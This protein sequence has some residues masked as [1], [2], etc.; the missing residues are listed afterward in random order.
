M[1]FTRFHFVE[2]RRI[3]FIFK[4]ILINFL[5]IYDTFYVGKYLCNFNTVAHPL[6]LPVSIVPQFMRECV[7]LIFHFL[8][9][10]PCSTRVTLKYCPSCFNSC[11]VFKFLTLLKWI[12][13][14]S[15][16]R[17]HQL[18]TNHCADSILAHSSVYDFQCVHGYRFK[19]S[20][21]VRNWS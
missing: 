17:Q 19:I 12:F 11:N 14:H 4:F 16:V 9:I 21:R 5:L 8:Y 20:F 15:T 10:T 3:S 6:K 2:F 13:T 7:S 18:V 1:N